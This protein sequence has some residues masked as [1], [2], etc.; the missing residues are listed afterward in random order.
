MPA[1]DGTNRLTVVL[2]DI[3]TCVTDAS[4]ALSQS[5]ILLRACRSVTPITLDCTAKVPRSPISYFV[6]LDQDRSP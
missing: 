3:L 1:S 2:L 4:H 5:T 6:P